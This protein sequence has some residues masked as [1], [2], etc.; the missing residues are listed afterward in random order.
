MIRLKDR[1]PPLKSSSKLNARIKK[2]MPIGHLIRI[3]HPQFLKTEIMKTLDLKRKADSNS[4]IGS[5]SNLQTPQAKTGVMPTSKAFGDEKQ[6]DKKIVTSPI[7]ENVKPAQSKS[8]E[9]TPI[10]EAKKAEV[11]QVVAPK[12]ALNLESILKLVEELH[13]RKTHRDNLLS[14]IKTLDDFK[15]MVQDDDS[16]GIESTHFQGCKLTIEDD[17][18]NTFTTKNPFIIKAVAEYVNKLCVGKLAEIE[19]HLVIPV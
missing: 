18:R 5:L 3:I 15:V 13:R 6:E 19:A 2:T 9:Q 10:L 12:P 8:Q 7:A 1:S 4:A 14:T 17:D 11:Q 16:E